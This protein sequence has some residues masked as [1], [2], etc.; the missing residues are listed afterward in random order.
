MLGLR[1]SQVVSKGV[2]TYYVEVRRVKE[3]VSWV[4]EVVSAEVVNTRCEMIR[5]VQEVINWFKEVLRVVQKVVIL[6]QNVIW[7]SRKWP[8]WSRK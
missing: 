3:V 1:G 4:K 6:E 2:N 8:S 7:D 5:G